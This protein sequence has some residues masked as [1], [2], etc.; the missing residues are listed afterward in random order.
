MAFKQTQIICSG[1]WWQN[2]PSLRMAE[3]VGHVCRRWR[4]RE[5]IR[6]SVRVWRRNVGLWFAVYQR[7]EANNVVAFLDKNELY[8]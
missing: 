1:V 3:I 6:P 4:V 7:S 8:H 2:Q 5:C